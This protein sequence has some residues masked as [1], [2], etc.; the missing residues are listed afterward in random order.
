[1]PDWNKLIEEQWS[2]KLTFKRLCEAVE[3]VL[4]EAEEDLEEANLST[5]ELGKRQNLKV[6]LD[7]IANNEPFELNSRDGKVVIDKD[8]ERTKEY[9]GALSQGTSPARGMVMMT[10]D[11]NPI[12][13]GKL[14]KSSEFG[15]KDTEYFVKKEIAARGQL[16][17]LIQAAIKAANTDAIVIKVVEDG[18]VIAEYD[19]VVGVGDT[20]KVAGV[21]P[22]SD[23]QLI[24][25]DGKPAVFIS[26]KDGTKPNHFGQWSGLTKKAGE[27]IYSHPEVAK[28][29][30][31]IK[32]F[33]ERQT[34]ENGNEF[35][36]HPRGL[37][38]GR[39]IKDKGLQLMSM[40]GQDYSVG[41]DGSVNNCDLVAQGMFELRTDDVEKADGEPQVVYTLTATHLHVRGG[42]TEFAEGYAPIFVTRFAGGR[43]NYG[44]RFMRVSIYPEKG[45][46]VHKW[47]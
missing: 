37:S 46:K 45:R 12:T 6:F 10:T 7:K 8:N 20:D 11:G 33:M 41:G 43:S 15:G 1:M 5:K 21:D 22:K 47:I 4:D 38:V 34:D 39:V 35:L 36:Q 28:F 18:K 16:D 9:L 26:H 27:A 32:P 44:I 29:I 42:G 13:L 31:D 40:F 19:D 24:R 30:E 2:D 23:F 14:Y 25:K 3:Q 17:D